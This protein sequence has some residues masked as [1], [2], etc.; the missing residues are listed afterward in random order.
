VIADVV[1]CPALESRGPT[2]LPDD[3]PLEATRTEDLVHEHFEI[4]P[5]VPIAM[6]IHRAVAPENFVAPSEPGFHPCDVTLDTP[7]P[8]VVE[9][10]YLV[11]ITSEHLVTLI[12]EE[13]R[14]CVNQINGF[15]RNPFQD[16]RAVAA[17]D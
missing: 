8:T 13:R 15:F 4:V 10:S 1:L 5:R 9:C 3:L 12:R 14:V 2:Y 17:M 11:V 6:K 16:V 7:L